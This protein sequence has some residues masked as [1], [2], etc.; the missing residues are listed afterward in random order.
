MYLRSISSAFPASSFTQRE[1]WEALKTHGRQAGLKGRSMGLLEKILLGDS[2]ID[3]RHFALGSPESIFQLDAQ[4]LNEAFEIHAPA[5]ASEALQGALDQADLSARDLDALFICSC[6]GYLCPGISSH[7]AERVG[8]GSGAYLQDLVGLGCGAAIP[9][10]RSADGF[11]RTFDRELRV[12]TV[13]VEICSACFYIDDDPG[14]LISLCLFGDGASASIWTNQPSPGAWQAHGFQTLHRPEDRE[15][16]RFVNAGGKLRNQLD[17]SVPQLAA[18]AVG[19]L[20]AETT[21]NPD[22]VLTHT[23]GRDV[24]NALSPV[25]KGHSLLHSE[26]ILRDYGNVS[27]PSIMLALEA[28][29]S[30]GSEDER[31]WLTSFG[32][33][34]AAHSCNLTKPASI[35]R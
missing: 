7:V 9:T 12:A 1:C 35:I 32:A 27:S 16:I 30:Q 2:G 33:G 18:E 17:R 11:L 10:M 13:C 6:T 22:V 24:L 5:L 4:Q 19:E 25:L 31:L 3:Q 21:G 15:K 23:G 28:Q 26:K 8:L 14:V 29:L 20:F 34:F